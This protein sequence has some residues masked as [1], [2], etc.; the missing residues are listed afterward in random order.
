[1]NATASM[2]LNYEPLSFESSSGPANMDGRQP[3]GTA[4]LSKI[5]VNLVGGEGVAKRREVPLGAPL[6]GDAYETVIRRCEGMIGA[7][8]QNRLIKSKGGR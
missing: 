5:V 8:L 3:G 7:L 2:I 4:K 1:M 6:G